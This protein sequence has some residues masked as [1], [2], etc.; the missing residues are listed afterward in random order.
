MNTS[1]R[2]TRTQLRDLEAELHAERARL[3]R[4]LSDHDG[5][6]W[7]IA[8]DAGDSVATGAVLGGLQTQTDARYDAIVAALA[9]IAEG[10]YGTCSGCQEPIP[11]GRLIVM[12][13]VTHCVACPS[14][15]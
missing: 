11:Y 3:E 4:S 9:R 8:A 6:S 2:L 1:H 10:N 13:E 15:V 12:P 14:R 5:G 7:T